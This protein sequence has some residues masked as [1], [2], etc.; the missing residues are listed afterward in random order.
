MRRLISFSTAAIVSVWGLTAS[1]QDPLLVRVWRPLGPGPNTLGQTENVVPDNEVVGA[2]SRLAPHPTNPDILYVGAVNGG[3]WKT[4]NATALRPTWIRLTDQQASLSIGALELDPTDATHQTLVAGTGRFSSFGRAGGARAGLFRTTD[5]GATWTPLDGGGVLAGKNISGAAA[6]GPVLLVSANTLDG[7][8]A[9]QAGIYRSSDAGATFA[10][11][12]AGFA[13]DLAS[14]P[15]SPNRLYTTAVGAEA[16]GTP[17]GLYRSLDTGATW[18]R[19]SDA[20]IDAQLR[21]TTSNVKLAVGTSNNVYVAIA[22]GG[23]LTGV[24]RSGD[25]GTTWAAMDVPVAH[26]GGQA[27]FHLSLAAEPTDPNIVY[28][29][30]DRQNIGDFGARNFSGRLFRG[31]AAQP[32]GS[33]FVH[34]TN[35]RS[36][37]PVGGGT[38]SNSSPHADS[39]DLAIDARGE[40][41]ECDDGGIYRRTRPLDNMG[42]WFSMNGTLQSTEFHNIAYDSNAHIVIGGAQDTGTPAEQQTAGRRWF[43]ISTADGGDVAVDDR[44]TPGF[45]VRYSSTQNLGGFR[46]QVVDAN[47]M[48]VSRV[49]P[50]HTLVG[51]GA[52]PSFGFTAPV[53]LNNADGH[54]LILGASN[55]AYESL[56]QG[57]TIRLVQPPLSVSAVAYGGAG[58]PDILYVGSLSDVWVRTAAFPAPLVRSATYPGSGSG[59]PVFAVVLDPRRPTTA[60]V[61]DPFTVYQTTDAG[62]TWTDI[63]GNL[64]ALDTG[65]LRSIALMTGRDGDRLVVGTMTG[66]FAARPDSGFRVWERLGAGLPRVSV[67]DLEYDATDDVLVAGTLGRGAWILNLV[68][69]AGGQ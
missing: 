10:Q 7:G 50:A 66:V 21:A 25:G 69:L 27:S 31:N 43:E 54:R 29:G 26:P 58:N 33:Q 53:E 32:L 67:Y 8:R 11:V 20:A 36:V 59:R 16:A 17:S 48:L 6:R 13:H 52:L 12:L 46:R 35:S 56:D 39:R 49:F 68:L 64:L 34:L 47:N 37:G 44:S 45:S 62:A 28:L 63:T 55:G 19:V 9:A 30:G 15:I 2:V 60:F 23:R 1:A 24:F 41:I 3:V 5:G 42:D 22:N 65:T 4:T 38:L 61:V 51:G 57:D 14:D 40:I 18:T